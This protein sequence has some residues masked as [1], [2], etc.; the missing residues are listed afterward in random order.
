MT[1]VD[2]APH[3]NNVALTARQNLSDGRLNVWG[4]SLQLETIPSGRLSVDGVPFEATNKVNSEP[5]NIRCEAQ[6]LQ[7]PESKA[8]WLHLLAT[9]ERRCE[10]TVHIHYSSGAVD[11]EWIR[12]SD[13]WPAQAHF[14]ESLAAASPSMHYP[15]HRQDNLSGQLWAVRIPVTRREPVRALRLPDN[16]A[17]HVFALTIET[18]R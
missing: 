17:L 13:F 8:E 1:A 2:L 4:N 10:E 16:P 3:L 12:V 6:Y 14:G 7:L 9:A 5:D 11:P 18:V 15:H